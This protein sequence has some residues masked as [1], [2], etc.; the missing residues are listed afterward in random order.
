MAYG[1]LGAIPYMD[2]TLVQ[3]QTE[4]EVQ[5][6]TGEVISVMQNTGFKLIMIK[7]H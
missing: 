2:D 5:Q 3:G 7:P 1:T 4:V 6:Y